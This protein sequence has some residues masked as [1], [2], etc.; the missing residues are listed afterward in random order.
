MPSKKTHQLSEEPAVFRGGHTRMARLALQRMLRRCYGRTHPRLCKWQGRA[1]GLQPPDRKVLT[2]PPPTPTPW[3]SRPP[4]PSLGSPAQMPAS[5]GL[6]QAELVWALGWTQGRCADWKA[7]SV[8]NAQPGASTLWNHP[9][10]GEALICGICLFPWCTF[11]QHHWVS[12]SRGGRDVRPRL[13]GLPPPAP[14][15]GT[16]RCSG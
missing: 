9:L 4:H 8:P 13:T 16:S 14:A 1:R 3:P 15:L 2:S 6:R 12:R 7:Y 5:Q 10:R 11:S